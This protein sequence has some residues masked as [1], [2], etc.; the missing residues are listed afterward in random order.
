M[1]AVFSKE[2]S[3]FFNSLVAYI[4]I[5]VFLAALGLL[6][7]VFPETSVLTH[8]YANLDPLFSLGPFVFLFLVPAITMR[9]FAEEKRSGTLEWL[10]TKP[11]SELE[12]VLA[13][14]FSS[15]FLVL[16]SLVP[17]LLYYYTVYQLG[18]PVGNVDSA[19][20]A[21]SYVGLFLLGMV[22]ASLGV[23]VSSVTQNQIVAFIIAVFLSF[24]FYSG[25]QS[26]AAIDVWGA[27]SY[28]LE[29]IGLAYHYSALSKGLIDTRNILYFISVI[30]ISLGATYIKLASRNW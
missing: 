14:Y 17:T 10:L 23:F 15:V 13:K 11:I 21:G 12:I 28:I 9:S 29:Y 5:G 4:I 27:Y 26:I 6:A 7:W 8:G 24:M 30:V 18:N 16:L 1:W 22:F 25:F 2:V 20:V 3:G 19:A